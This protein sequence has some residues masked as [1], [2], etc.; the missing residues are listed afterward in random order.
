MVKN[1]FL[2]FIY[3]LAS[4]YIGF[5]A[6][7]LVTIPVRMLTADTVLRS[8]V[9]FLITQVCACISLFIL[10]RRCGYKDATAGYV[11]SWKDTLPFLIG[12]AAYV[13]LNVLMNYSNPAGLNAMFLTEI[14]VGSHAFS[15]A[16]LREGAAGM[17]FLGIFIMTFMK[18]PVMVWGYRMGIGKRQV[19]R[20]ILIRE[21]EK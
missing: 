6:G 11:F 1:G 20:E 14:F 21:K 2:Y 9:I 15:L 13:L 10:C 16:E 18:Y 7:L 3:V 5:L 4:E 19:D 12:Q 8:G 17:L